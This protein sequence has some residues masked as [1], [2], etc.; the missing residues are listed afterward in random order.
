MWAAGRGPDWQ[1]TTLWWVA[2]V[3]FILA[4]FR[5]LRWPSPRW[6]PVPLTFFGAA[7]SLILIAFLGFNATS[8]VGAALDVLLF[9]LVMRRTTSGFGVHDAT[10]HASPGSGPG[11]VH[12]HRV[13]RGIGAAVAALFFAH[14]SAAILLRPWHSTW[15]STAYERAAELPGDELVPGSRYVMNHAV[16]IDAP[17]EVVWPWLVQMGQDRGGFYSYD[18][19]ERALGD[20]IH[21]ADRIVPAWQHLEKGDLVRAT[22]PNYLGGILGRDIG[23]RVARID[24]GYALVL[25]NWGSF[26]VH[27]LD[28]RTSILHVR[29]RGQGKPS[30]AAVPFAPL[31]LLM[32]EPA[33]FTMERGMLLGIKARAEAQVLD[34]DG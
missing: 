19:L 5:L 3:A 16:R 4:G 28:D 27:R 30:L 11:P 14:L 8:L 2:S 7:A 31:G 26:V 13:R 23:W 33:H 10:A 12:R 9:G 34:N 17:A 32:F 24:P 29:T 20:D 25:E 1:I 18:W 6:H 21:N 15:G 22:Q